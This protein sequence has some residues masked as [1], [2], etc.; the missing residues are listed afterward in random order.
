MAVMI[1]LLQQSVYFVRTPSD[2]LALKQDIPNYLMHS[3]TLDAGD[4]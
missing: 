1:V 3:I 4:A 2:F